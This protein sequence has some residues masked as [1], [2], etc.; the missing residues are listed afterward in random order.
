VL[1]PLMVG[2]LAD[3]TSLKAAL[4]V[5]PV[6]LVLAATGLTLLRRAQ[7]RASGA[8]GTAVAPSCSQ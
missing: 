8:P 7:V 1:A 2:T 5:V 3:A 4:W 6:M